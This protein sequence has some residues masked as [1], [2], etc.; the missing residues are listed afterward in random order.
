MIQPCH[1]LGWKD[2]A[3]GRALEWVSGDVGL[4]PGLAVNFLY[5]AFGKSL[6]LSLPQFLIGKNGGSTSLHHHGI[7][8]IKSIN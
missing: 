1:L 3:V 6:N 5:V 7:L 4:I 8:K 2:D